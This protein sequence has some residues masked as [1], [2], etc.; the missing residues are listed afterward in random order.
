MG[1]S[2]LKLYLIQADPVCYS[3]HWIDP[4]D[5]VAAEG[6]GCTIVMGAGAEGARV[7]HDVYHIM[8]MT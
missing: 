7:M 5:V 2:I 1:S 4:N 6:G 3:Q 8:Y